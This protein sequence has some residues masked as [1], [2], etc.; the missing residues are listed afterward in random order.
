V[1]S[2]QRSPSHGAAALARDPQSSA[3]PSIGHR[4]RVLEQLG[5]GGMAV[6]YRVRDKKRADAVALVR[7]AR[8]YEDGLWVADGDPQL[9]WLRL[10]GAVELA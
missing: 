5:R 1:S 10:I 7:S 8:A 9:A 3:L 2:S 4:Y 6:V